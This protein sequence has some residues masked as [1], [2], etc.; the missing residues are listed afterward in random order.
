MSLT[1]FTLAL[2]AAA[3]HALW[4][5]ASKRLGGALGVF[6]VAFCLVGLALVPLALLLAPAAWDGLG[7]AC[8]LG[9][10]SFT[11]PTSPCSAPPIA[12]ANRRRST[13]WRGAGVAGTAAVAWAALG[14]EVSP[15]GGLGILAVCAGVAL[16]GVRGRGDSRPS[17]LGLLVGVAITGYSVVDKLGVGHM[18]P[19]T[20]LAGLTLTTA[21]CLTPYAL[22]AQPEECREAW[23]RRKGVG[24]LLGLAMMGAY[25]LV[26]F[27]FRLAPVGYVVAVRECSVVL[28]AVL[29]LSRHFPGCAGEPTVAGLTGRQRPVA[30]G[31]RP[32][33]PRAPPAKR[34]R[35]GPGR[36]PWATGGN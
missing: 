35:G 33:C 22:L 7:L 9:T 36:G 30:P 5:L 4:N 10:G 6:C 28:A 20:Y 14:E 29:G 11:P 2:S 31:W 26:L 12:T 25:L 13:R 8:L 3:L 23:A 34:N 27:A 18:H 15:L 1:A 17:A 19:L 24:L 16:L 21:A 32:G